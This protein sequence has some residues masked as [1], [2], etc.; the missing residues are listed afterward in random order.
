MIHLINRNPITMFENPH[1]TIGENRAGISWVPAFDADRQMVFRIFSRIG[2]IP[3]M[4][5]VT[6]A[7]VISML[8]PK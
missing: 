3:G 6:V 1:R 5:S 8:T 2:R 7:Q 4:S